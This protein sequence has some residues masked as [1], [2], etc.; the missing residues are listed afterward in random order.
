[1]LVPV[2]IDI[3]WLRGEKLSYKVNIVIEKIMAIMPT[4]QSSKAAKAKEKAIRR[5][6]RI[7]VRRLSSI[8]KLRAKKND[9][10]ISAKR[11]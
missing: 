3:V 6:Y 5:L 8:W 1:L 7:S 4:P 2:K 10:S 11:F 9:L